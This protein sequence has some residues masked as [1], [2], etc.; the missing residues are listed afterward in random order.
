[1][2]DVTGQLVCRASINGSQRAHVLPQ[3]PSHVPITHQSDAIRKTLLRALV[4]AMAASAM[5][6]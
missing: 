5:Q 3:L 4:V 1:M 6:A 2:V